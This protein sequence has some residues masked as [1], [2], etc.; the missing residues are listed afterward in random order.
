M[1]TAAKNQVK[2]LRASILE[3]IFARAG[4]PVGLFQPAGI[5]RCWDAD[6]ASYRAV[7]ERPWLQS[8]YVDLASRIEHELQPGL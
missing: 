2:G 1:V 5:K 3:K 8:R 7:R 4:Y 6:H